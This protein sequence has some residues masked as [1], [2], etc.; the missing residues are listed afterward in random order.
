MGDIHEVLNDTVELGAL[1]PEPKLG[2]ILLDTGCQ[3]TEVLR[4][5]GD[6]TT[7]QTHRDT[8]QWLGTMDDIKVDDARDC[9]K[10]CE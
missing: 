6:G 1:V 2:A 9:I 7:V 4:G 8:T 3:R 10:P 5:L